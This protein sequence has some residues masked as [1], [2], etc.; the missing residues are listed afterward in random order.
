MSHSVV[1]TSPSDPESALAYLAES[2][3][4]SP[5]LKQLGGDSFLHSEVSSIDVV[6]AVVPPPSQ[7]YY[8]DW[9]EPCGE[10]LFA[11]ALDYL[12]TNASTR[13]L[14]LFEDVTSFPSDPY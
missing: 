5:V 6:T 4:G 1:V 8:V 11:Y 14:V 12:R 10:W 9:G 13:P 2:L 7:G 3:E